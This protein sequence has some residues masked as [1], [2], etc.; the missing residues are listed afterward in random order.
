MDKSEEERDK[1]KRKKRKK[2]KR[3]NSHNEA[4]FKSKIKSVLL[5]WVPIAYNSVS[6]CESNFERVPTECFPWRH[7][8][9]RPRFLS[10]NRS[11]HDAIGHFLTLALDQVL[12][13]PVSSYLFVL[14]FLAYIY[15]YKR[16][17]ENNTKHS[18]I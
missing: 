6:K 3:H 11:C 18:R 12:L 13:L 15:I 7:S 9:G 16:E 10:T 8:N 17:K 5:T 2:R 14:D 4:K 1:D